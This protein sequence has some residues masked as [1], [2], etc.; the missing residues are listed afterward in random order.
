[1]RNVCV[2]IVAGLLQWVIRFHLCHIGD[3]L[4][5]QPAS[6]SQ[7]SCLELGRFR[8][9]RKMRHVLISILIMSGMASA[10]SA[11]PVHGLLATMIGPFAGNESIGA[12]DHVGPI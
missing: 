2:F 5:L 7:R 6:A 9:F 12:A 8:E 3:D 10:T 4:G 1:M 11:T